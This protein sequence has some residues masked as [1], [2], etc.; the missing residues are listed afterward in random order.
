MKA[1]WRKSEFGSWSLF[2]GENQKAVIAYSE[3]RCVWD[4]HFV[5]TFGVVPPKEYPTF[6]A[7]QAAAVDAVIQHLHEEVAAL[8]VL[9][10][11]QEGAK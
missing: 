5:I 10:T 9:A 6:Y 8:V 2:V 3:R 4:V 7:A 1:E 11:E